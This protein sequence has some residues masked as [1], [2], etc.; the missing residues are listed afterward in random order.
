MPRSDSASD[1]DD[2]ERAEKGILYS[3]E[4]DT[5][6]G[7]DLSDDLERENLRNNMTDF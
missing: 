4:E 5:Y 1:L 3:L 6:E 2:L 7:E